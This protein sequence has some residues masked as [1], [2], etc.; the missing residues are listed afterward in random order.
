LDAATSFF[1]HWYYHLPNYALA[2]MMYA[3]LGR[4]VLGL[5]VDPNWT[6]FIWKGFVAVSNPAVKLTRAIT[7]DA[8]PLQVVVL[9]AILWLLAARVVLFFEFARWGLAPRLF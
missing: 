8:V 2:V 7:P 4:F 5:F 3:A 9:F 6:N 1:Q